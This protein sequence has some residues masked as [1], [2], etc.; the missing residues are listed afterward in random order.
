MLV[1]YDLVIGYLYPIVK[2]KEHFNEWMNERRKERAIEWIASIV[3]VNQTLQL[4][5]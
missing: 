1:S 3:L 5:E 4:A 2:L